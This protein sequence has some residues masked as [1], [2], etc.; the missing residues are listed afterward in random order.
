MKMKRS[1]VAAWLAFALVLT[2]TS[3]AFARTGAEG[4]TQLAQ[5]C[6]PQPDS[7]DLHRVICRDGG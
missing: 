1:T 5:Y 4:G 7:W 6:L 2:A 3:G